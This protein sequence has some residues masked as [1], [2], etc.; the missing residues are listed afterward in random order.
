[1]FPDWSTAQ[2]AQQINMMAQALGFGSPIETM[3]LVTIVLF[4]FWQI[5]GGRR[6]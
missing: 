2:W 4:I 5:F 1:M 6:S 3:L